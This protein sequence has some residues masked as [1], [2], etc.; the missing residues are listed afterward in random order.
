ME[1]KKKT[2]KKPSTTKSW[3]SE[4]INKIEKPLGRLTEER[5]NP[6]EQNKK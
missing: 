6:N 3:F 5:K 2:N 4:K 1:I